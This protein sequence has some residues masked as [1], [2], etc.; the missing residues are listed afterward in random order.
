MRAVLLALLLIGCAH[1]A[2]PPSPT[3]QAFAEVGAQ[4][5]KASYAGQDK[6][7]FTAADP[8]GNC[9]RFAYNYQ[10]ALA[11]RGI[12]AWVV[13]CHLPHIGDH[14]YAKTEQGWILDVRYRHPIRPAQEDCR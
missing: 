9:A 5:R 11:R 12:R 7:P 10:Y 8:Y 13:G 1:L 2:T 6:R 4:G 14:A 3:E